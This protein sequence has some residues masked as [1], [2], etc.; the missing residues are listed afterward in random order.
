L[1]QDVVVDGWVTSLISP[2]NW[3]LA[4]SFQRISTNLHFYSLTKKKIVGFLG[5]FVSFNLLVPLNSVKFCNKYIFDI[6]RDVL[7]YS[8][9]KTVI[10]T[11]RNPWSLSKISSLDVVF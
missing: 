11:H 7:Q 9:T 1:F 6:P 8:R 10:L 3:A 5:G 4:G 2:E